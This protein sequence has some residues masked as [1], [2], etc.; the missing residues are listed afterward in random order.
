LRSSS[1]V[2]KALQT[3]SAAG[4]NAMAPAV[5]V[6]QGGNAVATWRRFDGTNN[7]IQAAAGP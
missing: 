3:L 6:N 4:Q 2:L 5:A 1:G 7:R